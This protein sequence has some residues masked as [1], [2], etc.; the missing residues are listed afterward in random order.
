MYGTV[1]PAT[2]NAAA[3]RAGRHSALLA[4]IAV[5][6]ISPRTSLGLPPGATASP[7]CF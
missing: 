5:A 7:M 1:T 3:A 6:W 2:D 4:R